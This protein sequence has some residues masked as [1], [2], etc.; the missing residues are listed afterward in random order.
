[1]KPYHATPEQADR[2][3]RERD[4][5]RLRFRCPDC[6]HARKSPDGGMFCTLGY[7]NETLMKADH[8][9]ENRGQFVFCKYFELL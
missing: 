1:M 5:H 7:P 9:V 3:R 8:F 2:F 6:V 4:L